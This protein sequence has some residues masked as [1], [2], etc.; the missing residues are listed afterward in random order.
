[1]NSISVR[2]TVE[3]LLHLAIAV[4]PFAATYF[5]LMKIACLFLLKMTGEMTGTRK[6]FDYTGCFLQGSVTC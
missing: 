1:M 6:V 5:K 4:C 2:T 3:L